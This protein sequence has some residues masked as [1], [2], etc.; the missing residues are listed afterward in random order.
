MPS[1]LRTICEKSLEFMTKHELLP[2]WVPTGRYVPGEARLTPLVRPEERLAIWYSPLEGDLYRR[3][4]DWRLAYQLVHS[5]TKR[6]SEGSRFRMPA[7]WGEVPLE[8]SVMVEQFPAAMA[9]L[10]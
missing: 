2:A 10:G 3:E 6:G 5:F 9:L 4:D 8:L 7:L 1:S